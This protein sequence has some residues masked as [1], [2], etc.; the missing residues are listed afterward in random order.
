MMNKGIKSKDKE[1][2]KQINECIFTIIKM[3]LKESESI[4]LERVV[5]KFRE[6]DYE[7]IDRLFEF[8]SNYFSDVTE[9][10]RFFH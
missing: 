8:H 3:L 2:Q 6:N 4:N 10:E 7:K 1:E 5:N 9:I